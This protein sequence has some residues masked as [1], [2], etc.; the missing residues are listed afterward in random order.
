MTCKLSSPRVAR[1]S[2]VKSYSSLIITD[3]SPSLNFIFA[4]KCSLSPSGIPYIQNYS[5]SP[6][7]LA[8]C[9]VMPSA[10]CSYPGISPL[11]VYKVLEVKKKK[12][13]RSY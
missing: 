9:V 11:I 4:R 6:K 10:V 1:P 3:L 8:T 13:K 5:G 2:E 12:K 7:P